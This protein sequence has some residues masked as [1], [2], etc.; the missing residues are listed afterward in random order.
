MLFPM[1]VKLR[2]YSPRRH[3]GHEEKRLNEP[4]FLS[5]GLA[6]LA[7]FYANSSKLLANLRVSPLK[8]LKTTPLVR[9]QS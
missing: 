4:D 6:L 3:E 9:F 8:G 7:L 5:F 2:K 1:P